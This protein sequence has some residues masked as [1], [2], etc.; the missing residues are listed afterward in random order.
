[1]E[2]IPHHIS[3]KNICENILKFKNGAE[4]QCFSKN[5]KNIV[6]DIYNATNFLSAKSNLT[7][8]CYCI[9]NDIK[10]IP[11]CI[12]CKKNDTKWDKSKRNYSPF[13][14]IKC[15]GTSSV[16]KNKVKQ[17][18]LIKYGV[19]NVSSLNEVK[20]KKIEKS[21]EKYGVRHTLQSKEVRD[22][23]IETIKKRYGTEH[24]LQNKDIINKIKKTLMIRYGVDNV[25]KNKDIQE[26]KKNTNLKKYNRIYYSQTHISED[27][28]KKLSSFDFLYEEHYIK[29][30]SLLTIAT[31]L[32]VNDGTVARYLHSHGLETQHYMVSDIEKD[33]REYISS[34][35]NGEIFYNTRTLIPPKEIDIYIPEYKLGIEFCGLF[36]HNENIIT[37]NGHLDKMNLT[38][39]KGIRMLFVYE[40]EWLF[41][42]NIIK[43]KLSHILNK[44]TKKIFA[45]KCS[46]KIISKEEK[47]EFLNMTHIQGNGRGSVNLGLF[48]NNKLI[49]CM[50]LINHKNDI[51]ELNRYATS[52]SVV[53]GFSKMLTFFKKNYSWKKI[54]TYADRRWSDGN[55]YIKCGLIQEHIT[56]PSYDYVI[57]QKRFHKSNF[58]KKYLNSPSETEFETTN[59]RNLH[60]IWNC[61]YIRF[62]IT[63]I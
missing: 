1:M 43:Q 20:N 14:G 49:A 52:C 34:I 28:I 33:L 26:K 55:L 61:G 39:K 8:R 3:L 32:G 10:E 36:W 54:F 50:T 2:N 27:I 58:R 44:E 13:C 9:Y 29:Q 60:R 42:N 40:D 5:N 19:E 48:Y 16:I 24:P 7:E 45:R 17:T 30:K 22:K 41:K 59:K 25:S 12:E 47:K 15:K 62:S 23:G 4:S 11:K 18:N 53:G 38:N 6:L 56:K 35:Y 37:K 31:E 21:I 63:N 57:N 46:I 51:Y